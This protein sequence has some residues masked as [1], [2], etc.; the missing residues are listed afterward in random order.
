MKK[1]KKG[2][3]LT[4]LIAVIVILAIL[5]LIG[6]PAYNK[7]RTNTLEKQYDNIVSL[8]ETAA[9]KFASVQGTNLTNVQELIDNGYIETDD[10]TN[11]VDPRNKESMNCMLVEITYKKGQYKTKM[12]ETKECDIN[13]ARIDNGTINIAIRGL[14]TN[15]TDY[16]FGKWIKEDVELSVD[17][18]KMES[19]ENIISYR[20]L[21]QTGYNSEF[22]T[23]QTNVTGVFNTIV[24]VEVTTDMDL[25]Y[26][27]STSVKIDKEKPV[28]K[29]VEVSGGDNWE[30][31]RTIKIEAT[32]QAGSGVA[33]YYVGQTPCNEYTSFVE[34]SSNKY[35]LRID[36]SE[37][38]EEKD[39]Y[40]CV[41]DKVGNVAEYEQIKLLLKDKVPP[42][43]EYSGENVKWT[44][45]DVTLKIK[46]KDNESGCDSSYSN[47]E[48]TINAS[49]QTKMISYTI[50]DNAGNETICSK[51]FNV[52][53][54]KDK[55]TCGDVT[56]AS[57]VWTTDDREIKQACTDTGGSG[58]LY[59]SYDW[60]YT[61]TKK[62][63][64]ITIKDAAGNT[65]TCT[66]N[67]Y[68]DKDKPTCGDV[69]GASK[70]WSKDDRIIKQ[71]CTDKGSGCA[72]TTYEKKFDT[73]TK[74]SNFV[75]KDNAGNETTCDSF[76][77]YVD[78][79]APECGTATGALTDW[80]K[81]DR[82]I[83][84]PCTDKGSGCVKAT[85]EKKYTTSK[86]TDTITIKDAV[87]NTN[88]CTYNVY[89]DKDAPECGTV[90]GASNAWKKGDRT[91][92][93][94]CTDTGGSGCVKAT[95][96]KKFDTTTKTS[97]FV[98]KDNAGNETAC[99][100]FN[101][102]VDNTKPSVS[103]GTNG[104]NTYSSAASTKVTVTDSHSGVKS[105]KYGGTK[106]SGTAPTTVDLAEQVSSSCG[107]SGASGNCYIYVY[108][109][110]KVGNC[111][112]VYSNAFKV[113]RKK[114]T[115]I[116]TSMTNATCLST[117]CSDKTTC[118]EFEVKD[119]TSGYSAIT[120]YRSH[121]FRGTAQNVNNNGNC[122]YKDKNYSAKNRLIN[123][124]NGTTLDKDNKSTNSFNV[125]SSSKL[126]MCTSYNANL[127]MEYAFK[128]CDASGNCTDVKDFTS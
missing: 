36:S 37:I 6:I 12:L 77:V 74:T 112:G 8:V 71:E 45:N 1:R 103:F 54:D 78:K 3:T 47:F 83:Q 119:D 29:D 128:A 2:F 22:A 87:G 115:I 34:N 55:P 49:T 27:A 19:S 88:T 75:M 114:P 124:I 101:V 93:Q 126:P 56:G 82:T 5:S 72:T 76:N 13:Q 20:W 46:C 42:T 15:K 62:T 96:E 10:G 85:Y 127:T 51:N 32:D 35:S 116:K 64:T 50:R 48:E 57:T 67:V 17:R 105:K 11:L 68:V 30:K 102:Y 4:E 81:G 123:Y 120:G 9:A 66:Y 41:K 92:K 16:K 100:S 53:V 95:Y 25:K 58:C 117:Y 73:T 38:L 21:T 80:T 63:D 43:C 31:G 121:C 109:C 14:E 7:I 122:Y 107:Y 89:V 70:T 33:G 86:K 61:K 52:Y 39:Y 84:Q 111:S 18:T 113:D 65:N 99:D 69:T 90:T 40:I 59:K 23:M 60:N 94:A 97:N 98:M 110:D 26:F 91:I 24:H 108:A 79:T 125:N 28:I 106:T 118:R 104:S 44:N